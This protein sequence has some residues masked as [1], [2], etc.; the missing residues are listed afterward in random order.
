MFFGGDHLIDLPEANDHDF[1]K[2]T[3]FHQVTKEVRAE[4]KESSPLALA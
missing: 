3:I 2:G 4:H 1:L